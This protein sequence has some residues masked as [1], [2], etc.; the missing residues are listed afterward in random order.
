[1]RR[2]LMHRSSLFLPQPRKLE[3]L[4]VRPLIANFVP[5]E[6][7][8]LASDGLSFVLLRRECAL[9]SD[10]LSTIFARHF[11]WK[12]FHIIVPHQTRTRLR[13]G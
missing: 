9:L 1:M 3:R 5:T 11:A 2:E 10:V 6:P 4:C 8:N 7:A 13:L 12:R